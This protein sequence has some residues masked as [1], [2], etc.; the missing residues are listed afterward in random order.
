MSHHGADPFDGEQPDN[1]RKL[2]SELKSSAAQYRG[3][4]GAY[5]DGMLT[6]QDEGSLQFAV[7][8]KDGK[9]VIDF[10]SPIAWFGMTPQQAMDLAASIM[11]RARLVAAE[12]GETV[13]ITI[14]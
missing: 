4:V 14:G 8:S 10:G 2:L 1:I 3:P 5:P 6:P 11:T 9:V 12:R 7:G 13:H